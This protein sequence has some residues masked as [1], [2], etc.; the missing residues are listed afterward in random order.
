MLEG[1]TIPNLEAVWKYVSF[2]RGLQCVFFPQAAKKE[3]E[4]MLRYPDFWYPVFILIVYGIMVGTVV[5]PC[6]VWLFGGSVVLN[7]PEVLIVL[8]LTYLI[9]S[10]LVL[11][12]CQGNF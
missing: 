8:Q 3:R 1:H 2:G 7:T 12:S 5:W 10:T 11:I 4:L 6:I 9:C